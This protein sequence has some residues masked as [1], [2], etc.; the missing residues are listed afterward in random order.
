[1]SC[2]YCDGRVPLIENWF[3]WNVDIIRDK[4]DVPNLRVINESGTAIERNIDYCP[5]C[6]DEL[7]PFGPAW[8]HELR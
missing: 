2:K 7:R 6:G 1:M 8:M 3:G 4:R 5:V